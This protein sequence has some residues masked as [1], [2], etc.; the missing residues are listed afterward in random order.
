M[1]DYNMGRV[2]VVSLFKFT[3]SPLPLPRQALVLAAA[4]VTVSLMRA[5]GASCM[6]HGKRDGRRIA[7]SSILQSR[8]ERTSSSYERTCNPGP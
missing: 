6:I 7:E 5:P 4:S 3:L 2:A 8:Y 1:R